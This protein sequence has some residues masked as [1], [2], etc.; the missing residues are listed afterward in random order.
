MTMLAYLLAATASAAQQAPQSDLDPKAT[1][2]LVHRYGTCVVKSAQQRAAEAILANVDNE[3]FYRKYSIL[4]MPRCVPLEGGKVVQV[5]FAGDQYRY[6]LA[7]ALVRRELA[8]LPAPDLTLVPKL[9]HREPGPPPSRLSASGKPLKDKDFQRA[10][11]S[12]Q[13]AQ[14]FTFLSRYGECVV[15]M[16]P[17]TSRALLLSDPLT[18]AE[19]A[20]FEALKPTL[21]ACLT[22]GETLTL[23]KLAIRGT[24]AINYY[25]LAKAAPASGLTA[26]ATQ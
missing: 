15:R 23:G 13:R 18:P 11:E 5:R 24:V 6:T 8:A 7:D 3:T 22:P 21:A 12:H 26:G 1:R 17:E 16:D 4:I 9:D 2:A 19:S 20:Q 10:L 25:R 14:A